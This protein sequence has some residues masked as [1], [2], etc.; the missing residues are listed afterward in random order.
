MGDADKNLNIQVTTTAPVS[1]LDR[2]NAKLEE[3]AKAQESAAKASKE[4]ADAEAYAALKLEAK[5]KAA[6]RAAETAKLEGEANQQL[7]GTV[8]KLSEEDVKAAIASTGATDKWTLSKNQAKAALKGLSLEVPILGRAWAFI[9]NPITAGIAGIV[10]AIAIWRTRMRELT[11]TFA[12]TEIASVKITNRD[13]VDAMADAWGEYSKVLAGID[14]QYNGI[15][16]RMDRMLEKTKQQNDLIMKLAGNL[17]PA[18]KSALEEDAARRTA[19]D[20]SYAGFALNVSASQKEAEAARLTNEVNASMAGVD[21][22]KKAEMLAAIEAQATSASSDVASAED[23]IKFI[24]EFEESNGLDVLTQ[25]KFARRYG[26]GTT[27]AEARRIENE[28]L[29]GAQTRLS[30]S[31]SR[32]ALVESGGSGNL[33]KRKRAAALLQE[34]GRQRAAGQKFIQQAVET[35]STADLD[36]GLQRFQS[37]QPMRVSPTGEGTTV[38]PE[39]LAKILESQRMI[40]ETFLRIDAENRRTNAALNARQANQR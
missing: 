18:T 29:S 27:V 14:E 38:S 20:E 26:Y 22:K 32:A 23:R 34:A 6:E 9:S 19:K 1:E 5:A 4:L 8:K 25:Q 13:R 37:G 17:D 21:P 10:G 7:Q 30:A 31:E 39:T 15:E 12:E 36:A 28:S 3:M 33:I 24:G 40:N 16:A 11:D 35:Q 2:Y